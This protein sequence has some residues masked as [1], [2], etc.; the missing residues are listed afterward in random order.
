VIGALFGV[1]AAFSWGG[2]DFV[3]GLVS[4]R[5]PTFFVVAASQ[6]VALLIVVPIA[7]AS[8]QPIPDGSTALTTA[9]AGVTG[10]TGVLALYHGF[11][12]GRISIVASIAGT[13]AALIP[14]AVAALG[15]EELSLLRITGFVCAIVAIVIVSMNA[16][17]SD[18]APDRSDAGTDT[19]S[20]A[21]ALGGAGYGLLA[22]SC[23]A[24]FSLIF[25]GIEAPG[26]LWLLSGLRLASVGALIAVFLVSRLVGRRPP[27]AEPITPGAIPSGHRGRAA[28]IGLL[29]AAGSGD[30]LGN[31]FFFLS[32][33]Q[34]GVAVAAVFT[35]IAP[36]TTVLFAALILRESI[37]RR[38]AIGIVLAA[39]ATVAIALG[40]IA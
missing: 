14:V 22:G 40:G 6:A 9:I 17:T 27:G 30:T 34:S 20:G 37:N 39:V 7:A 35:S 19:S 33:Q 12:H 36:V 1:L 18:T 3:G 10:G 5:L 2:G 13:L 8:G 23:F 24:G 29:A 32:A 4:R 26:T 38:Q 28:L 15:G 16:D 31:L 25:A 21:A 11:A